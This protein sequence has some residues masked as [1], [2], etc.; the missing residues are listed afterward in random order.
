MTDKNNKDKHDS[1]T[2]DPTPENSNNEKG[3]GKPL[4]SV[5]TITFPAPGFSEP[6]KI[7]VENAGTAQVVVAGFYLLANALWQVMG[8][9]NAQEMS[10]QKEQAILNSLMGKGGPPTPKKGR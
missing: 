10:R 2:G 7:N 5:I 9:L 8:T 6:E 4:P 3:N 1:K